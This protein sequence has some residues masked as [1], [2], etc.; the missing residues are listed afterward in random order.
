MVVCVPHGPAAGVTLGLLAVG[1]EHE[2]AVAIRPLRPRRQSASNLNRKYSC[3]L[4][5]YS[6][7]DNRYFYHHPVNIFHAA[8]ARLWPSP[9]ERESSHE[10]AI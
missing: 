9:S 1:G 8:G 6:T 5:F 4:F 3:Q 7:V 10:R 2:P